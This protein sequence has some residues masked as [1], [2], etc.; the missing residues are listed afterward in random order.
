MA[1]SRNTGISL[2]ISL[3]AGIVVCWSLS[4]GLF[5]GFE[6]FLEDRLFSPRPIDSRIIIISIDNESV[7]RI[8]QWPWPREVFAKA[9]QNLSAENPLV[10][11]I[12]VIFSEP[13]RLGMLDDAALQNALSAIPYPVVM[14]V[15]AVSL[16]LEAEPPR[17]GSLISPLPVFTRQQNISLGHVNLII[18]ADGI[19]RRFPSGVFA[20]GPVFPAFAKKLAEQ[21]GIASQDARRLSSIERIVYSAAAGHFPRIPFWRV[22]ENEFDPQRFAGKVVLIGATAADLH[23]EKPTPV[24]R[25]T[26]MPGV[27]IQA[28]I[29][30]MI[31]SGYRL[32]PLS[33]IR[34]Y[35]WIIS[36]ALLS[37]L[38]FLFMRR[39]VAP[40]AVNAGIGIIHTGIAVLLFERGIAANI[41]HINLAWVFATAALFAYRYFSGERERR[42]LTALFS[43]Y[44]SNDVLQEI[45]KNPSAVALGGEERRITVLFTDIRGFTTLSESVTAPELVAIL[46]RYFTRMTD[47]ILRHQGV[48]DKYIGDA[49][50]AFWGAPVADDR[51]A[52][53]A[54]EA[55]QGMRK[56][57]EDL[58]AE[59]R[60][61]G[62]KEISIGIGIYTGPAVVGNIGSNERFDYTAMGD[63]VNVASRLEGLTKE[64]KTPIIIGESTKQ[65]L[66]DSF[67]IKPLGSVSV[68]GRNE[69][70][71]IY[72]LQ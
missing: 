69:P 66:S 70:L 22:Y 35:A 12:D 2:L 58:N 59:L 15:E 53:H 3:I 17:A 13:S 50:M 32:I 65:Q 24:S 9:L 42:E 49:I 39:S 16:D 20:D 48:V 43:K 21:S 44:V 33:G 56:A 61:E 6:N 25:G 37:L 28:Q 26:E 60:N 18:D 68:K 27:E 8:G 11:G 7:A 54:L 36:A 46:N 4:L 62:K 40:I 51:Q 30:N 55:A 38:P 14:P 64:Y 71:N 67:E 19:V 1:L 72:G 29:L 34:S 47:E 31:A 52:D 5:R 57:L 45:L 41:I 63:T 10:V 23:D